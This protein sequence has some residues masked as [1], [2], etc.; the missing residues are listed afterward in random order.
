MRK[1]KSKAKKYV[2]TTVSLPESVW[3][4]LRIESVKTKTSM[5]DLIAMKIR[6]LKDLK[7]RLSF[8]D[9]RES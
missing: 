5:G 3:K 9:G 7:S 1:K 8:T 6:E 2:R 4:E